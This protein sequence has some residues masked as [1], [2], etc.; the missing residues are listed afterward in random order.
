VNWVTAVVPIESTD[1]ALAE[2]LRLGADVQILSPADLRHR[3]QTVRSLAEL[4]G[5]T[6]AA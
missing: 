6:G 2:F 4:Y 1:H 5:A 3:M